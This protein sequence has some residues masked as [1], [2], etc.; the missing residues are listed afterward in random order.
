[1]TTHTGS[2]ALSGACCLR[3][4]SV[5][6]PGRYTGSFLRLSAAVQKHYDAATYVSRLRCVTAHTT[7]TRSAWIA[8]VQDEVRDAYLQAKNSSQ[9][10]TVAG[11]LLHKPSAELTGCGAPGELLKAMRLCKRVRAAETGRLLPELPLREAGAEAPDY[12]RLH[13]PDAIPSI[14][15]NPAN[16]FNNPDLAIA[17][18]R[19]QSA[20]YLPPNCTDSLVV[21]RSGNVCQCLALSLC[22]SCRLRYRR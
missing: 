11:C 4:G 12:L 9:C 1:M 20:S 17:H 14:D 18:V 10:W 16:G 6:L 8:Q 5:E 13:S 22:Q 15:W 3:A 2:A 21:C 19:Q 7:G